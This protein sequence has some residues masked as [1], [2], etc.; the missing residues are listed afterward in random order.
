[1]SEIASPLKMKRKMKSHI[2][3]RPKDLPK[4]MKSWPDERK[5]EVLSENLTDVPKDLSELRESWPKETK[6]DASSSSSAVGVIQ[7]ETRVSQILSNIL[8]QNQELAMATVANAYSSLWSILQ[9]D[10]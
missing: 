7:I 9:R 3:A 2:S 6:D 10:L 4:S 5:G 1:M 8:V